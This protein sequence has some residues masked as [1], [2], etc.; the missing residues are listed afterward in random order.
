MCA[1]DVYHVTCAT[2]TRTGSLS[3]P[4]I[5]PPFHHLPPPFLSRAQLRLRYPPPPSGRPHRCRGSPRSSGR[6]PKWTRRRCSQ[7]CDSSP[8]STSLPPAQPLASS[9]ARSLLSFTPS[10]PHSLVTPAGFTGLLTEARGWDMVSL[11]PGGFGELFPAVSV[12][13]S[14]SDNDGG[15][16]RG[17][18]DA[19][20]APSRTTPRGTVDE[21]HTIRCRMSRRVPPCRTIKPKQEKGRATA[22]CSVLMHSALSVPR[23]LIACTCPIPCPKQHRQVSVPLGSFCTYMA[24]QD[25]GRSGDDEPLCVLLAWA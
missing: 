6:A 17:R 18:I 19:H 12:D 20:Y 11:Q 22:L 8:R 10:H 13:L 15:K 4:S 1:C 14:G 2:Q 7:V 3:P 21:P 16:A 25:D 24:R 5:R 9:L 23:A